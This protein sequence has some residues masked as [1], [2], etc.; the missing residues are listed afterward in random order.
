VLADFKASD[1]D[2]P[3]RIIKE[4]KID[5]FIGAYSFITELK[6]DIRLVTGICNR[7]LTTSE[8]KLSLSENAHKIKDKQPA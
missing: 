5:D 4:A 1:S 6:K 8:Q 3:I 7:D 2:N